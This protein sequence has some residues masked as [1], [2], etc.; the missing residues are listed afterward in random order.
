MLLKIIQEEIIE[1][2]FECLC[3]VDVQRV[4]TCTCIHMYVGLCWNYLDVKICKRTLSAYV[5][6][7]CS[8]C[9]RVRVYICMLVYGAGI[10][11][12]VEF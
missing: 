6:W 4:Y 8:V 10:I 9:I 2:N 1:E 3:M 12:E 11:Q 7:M 5:W